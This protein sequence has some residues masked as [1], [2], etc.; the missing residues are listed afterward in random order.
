VPGPAGE[1][2]G[3]LAARPRAGAVPAAASAGAGGQRAA[4]HDHV[5]GLPLPQPGAEC[6]LLTFLRVCPFQCARMHRTTNPCKASCCHS[7]LA[8]EHTS[9]SLG[10]MGL[11]MSSICRWKR[12]HCQAACTWSEDTGE[13]LPGRMWAHCRVPVSF[14]RMCRGL[15][16]MAR[17]LLTFQPRWSS[18]CVTCR[19]TSTGAECVCYMYGSML[20]CAKTSKLVVRHG[21]F[22]SYSVRR[23]SSNGP[24]TGRGTSGHLHHCQPSHFSG[25]RSC[26][27]SSC[28]VVYAIVT[29]PANC[30]CKH[31]P[32]TVKGKQDR[33]LGASARMKMVT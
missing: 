29:T 7:V 3:V 4:Q 6:G 32:A 24:K 8:E 30:H 31:C 9:I 18:S 23:S 5:R 12:F 13:Q 17:S 27:S 16:P 28:R 2:G 15:L 33:T 22:G 19:T 10:C 14:V 25:S 21:L 1:P 20:F 26:G 11:P